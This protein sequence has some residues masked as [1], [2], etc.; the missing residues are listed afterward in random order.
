MMT[1]SPPSNILPGG[2]RVRYAPEPTRNSAAI[3]S[4]LCAPLW[5]LG[6]ILPGI[7]A[8]FTGTPTQP[9]VVEDLIVPLC[10]TVGPVAGIIAGHVG[11]YRAIKHPRLRRG[12]WLA[13]MGLAF[14]Y[15]WLAGILVISD[16]GPALVNWL[17]HL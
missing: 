13:V 11:L 15:L 3:A 5:P 14:G 9:A 17:G 2:A 4:L 8:L 7:V 10:L 6:Y 1:Q 16:A 12:W